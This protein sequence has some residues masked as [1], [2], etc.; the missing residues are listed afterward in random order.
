MAV[1]KEQSTQQAQ[2]Q[3]ITKVIR[4]IVQELYHNP[5]PTSWWFYRKSQGTGAA[6]SVGFILLGQ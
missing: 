1:P 5:M 6:E 2:S 4:I 3:R